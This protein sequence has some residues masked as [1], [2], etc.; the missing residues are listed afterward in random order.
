[1]TGRVAGWSTHQLGE[2]L[3]SVSELDSRSA[4]I[5]VAIERAVDALEADMGAVVIAGSVEASVGLPEDDVSAKE[6]ITQAQTS[7][8]ADIPGKGLCSVVVVPVDTEPP[9]HLL[10][11]RP[12]ERPFDHEEVTLLR[13]M[14]R[15]FALTLKTISVL[16]RERE[17]HGLLERLL[18]IQSSISHGT[19]LQEVLDSITKGLSELVGAEVAGVRLIDPDD[20]SHVQL[21]SVS[22]VPDHV[23]ARIRRGPIGEGAGGRAVAEN[24]LVTIDNYDLDPG[25]IPALAEDELQSAMAAPVHEHGE[26]VGSLAVATYT[27]GRRFS[28]GEEEA[29]LAFAEHASL[30]LSDARTVEA[31]RDAQRAKEMFL[32]MVSHELKT[33]LTVIMGTLGT[34]QKHGDRLA[35]DVREELLAA[36]YERGKDLRRLI[37]RLL[38]GGRAELARAQEAITLRELVANA[39][40]GFDHSRRL[41]V[42]DIP[43]AVVTT[44]TAAVREVIGVLLEN[45]VSHSPVGCEITVDCSLKEGVAEVAVCNPGSLADDLDPTTLFLPFQRGDGV[46][47]SG[48]GLGL[49]IARRLAEAIDGRLDVSAAKGT[50]RFTLSFPIEGAAAVEPPDPSASGLRGVPTRAYPEALPER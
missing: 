31:M 17:R 42:G 11:A 24:R 2:F 1:M 33:P 4:A 48:V 45:A 26:V 13:G 44:D 12:N 30:A 36:S 15:V 19:P 50:V 46:R 41:K 14:G 22:G 34:I 7:D 16:E 20:P 8:R 9:G 29:L 32:T 43:E 37:D 21:V 5:M 39:T 47:T 18:R 49:Y 3:A 6:I 28:K 10:I 25:S 40:R 23:V 35:P 27:P 38:Q